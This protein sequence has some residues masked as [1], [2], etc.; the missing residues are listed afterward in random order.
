M[1]NDDPIIYPTTQLYNI[2]LYNIRLTQPP[3]NFAIDP[4][5]E[6]ASTGNVLGREMKKRPTKWVRPPL[7][8]GKDERRIGWKKKKV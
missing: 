8:K 2:Q 1:T 5:T 6:R 3:K 4:R 7:Q